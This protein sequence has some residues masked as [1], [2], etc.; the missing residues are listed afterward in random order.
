[1]IATTMAVVLE[2]RGIVQAQEASPGSPSLPSPEDVDVQEVPIPPTTE[3]SFPDSQPLPSLDDLLES[4]P[5]TAPP[6]TPEG[7]SDVTFIIER[8]QIEGNTAF[9]D[10]EI[11]EKVLARYRGKPI[12]FSDL[13][14]IETEITQLYQENGYVNSGALIPP[15]QTEQDLLVV[16]VIEGSID[17]SQITVNGRLS[18]EYIRSRLQRGTKA[19]FNI[20]ELQ[21]A[22]QLLQLNPLVERINAELSVGASRNRWQL[23]IDV[24]QADAFDPSIFA[25]NSRT[26]SVGSFQRGII[27]RHNNF[28]RGG[29]EISFAYRNTDGSNDYDFDFTVPYN[30][31]NG[32]V[33]FGYRFIDSDIIEPPF[34]SLRINSQ[35]DEYKLNIRQPIIL[36]ASANSTQEL[37]VGLEFSRQAN[38]TTIYNPN[39]QNSEPFPLSRGADENGETN[40]IALRFFQD[41]TRRTRFDVLAGRS[42]FSL[43]LDAFDATI[44]EG[45]PDG[46]FFAWRGQLQW[47]RLLDTESNTTILLR[48]D[49][50]LTPNDLI[51][52]EQFS[53][54]GADSVRGYRQDSLLGDNGIIFSGEFR[55]PFVRWNDNQNTIAIIPFTDLGTVWSDREDAD[56]EEDTVFSVG[57]GLQLNI[58]ERFNARLDWGIPLVEVDDSDRTLQEDG[59]YFSLEYSPF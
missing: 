59:L 5:E 14:E 2:S 52:L 31:L 21:E 41:W 23:D 22:L 58:N 12:S 54:G 10:A 42:Q 6:Q 8:F 53:V 51:A 19:P 47:V 28:A 30:S 34:D 40:V 25:N 17:S 39:T 35:T 13:L 38:S 3:P 56:Q 32:T 44:T 16:Q 46:N 36:E 11:Q 24:E 1:M 50:Q 37:A 43:G 33:S 48:S 45:Q 9:S 18:E 4:T 7:D 29:E 20:N 27:L 15:Q 55:F 26:P 57:L 49:V